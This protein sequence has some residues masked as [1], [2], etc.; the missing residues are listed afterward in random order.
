MKSGVSSQSKL[1]NAP[2]VVATA[3]ARDFF[4]N[5]SEISD[6]LEAARKVSLALIGIGQVTEQAAIVRSGYFSDEEMKGVQMKGAV[7]NISTSFLDENG[8]RVHYDGEAR[9][10]GLTLDEIK[11]IPNVIAIVAGNGVSAWMY[12]LQIWIR[13][14]EQSFGRIHPAQLSG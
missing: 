11:A 2:A 5:E 3:Q 7:C 4:L 1:L 14:I 10:I 9:M 6:V 8:E 13:P 12:S